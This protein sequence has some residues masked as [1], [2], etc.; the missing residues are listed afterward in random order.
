MALENCISVL[1]EWCGG[2]RTKAVWQSLAEASS[3]WDN[4]DVES[5]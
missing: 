5:F 1:V 3:D 4:A 2:T